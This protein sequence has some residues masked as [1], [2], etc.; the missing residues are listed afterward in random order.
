MTDPDPFSGDRLQ[1]RPDAE[2]LTAIIRDEPRPAVLS[3]DAPWGGGKT[4]F[5]KMWREYLRAEGYPTVYFNAWETDFVEDPLVS[6]IGELQADL[7]PLQEANVSSTL[8]K[9]WDRVR[10]L[11]AGVIR[12]TGPLALRVATQGIM[13]VEDVRGVLGSIANSDAE[14]SG[15]VADLARNRLAAHEAEKT[16]VAAFRE[17]LSKVAQEL[18]SQDGATG[19][20]IVF[21]DELDRCRPDFAVALLERVKHLFSV[22]GVVFILALDREQLAHTVRAIY[23]QGFGA[24]GYLR[25]F[26]E[27]DYKLP[28]PTGT[29]FVEFLLERH[30]VVEVYQRNHAS[31]DEFQL[32]VPMFSELARMFDMSL[33]DQEQAFERLVLTLKAV[34]TERHYIFTSLVILFVVLR[35]QEEKLYHRYVRGQANIRELLDAVE[36]RT[37]GRAFLAS[38]PGQYTLAFLLASGRGLP[39][40]DEMIEELNSVEKDEGSDPEARQRAARLMELIRYAGRSGGRGAM[41]AILPRLERIA[42]QLASAE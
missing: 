30:R 36:G 27:F 19:P 6:F 5:V 14:I 41:K 2:L 9:H 10:N 15:Y 1:R 16:A 3:V 23:G 22:R 20:L 40:V 25:R 18:A 12:S 34:D 24:S 21:V 38:H 32:I 33:R 39:G 17:S 26:I 4:T 37:G 29:Q 31:R 35:M 28:L 13:N 8:I 7:K 42:Q 11:G